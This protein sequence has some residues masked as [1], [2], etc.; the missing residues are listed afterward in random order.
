MPGLMLAS[1]VTRLNSLLVSTYTTRHFLQFK[2]VFCFWIASDFHLML[3]FF[4][5]TNTKLRNSLDSKR[6]KGD[7]LNLTQAAFL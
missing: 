1:L 4:T 6:K 3:F 7:E 2:T 5:P